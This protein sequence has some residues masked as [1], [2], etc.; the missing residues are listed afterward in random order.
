MIRARRRPRSIDAVTGI[1]DSILFI[2]KGAATASR[3]TTSVGAA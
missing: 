3:P 1:I 2:P